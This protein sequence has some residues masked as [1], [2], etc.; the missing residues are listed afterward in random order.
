MQDVV[1]ELYS[2]VQVDVFPVYH[3]YPRHHGSHLSEHICELND[4]ERG[5]AKNSLQR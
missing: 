5:V 2:T 3:I 1:F 4:E